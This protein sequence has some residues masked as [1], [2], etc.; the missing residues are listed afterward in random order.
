VAEIGAMMERFDIDSAINAVDA[1]IDRKGDTG[2]TRAA[3]P[4]RKE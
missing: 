3:D 4:V 2:T 1:I